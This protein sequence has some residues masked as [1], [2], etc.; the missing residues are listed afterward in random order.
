M[1]IFSSD[2]VKSLLRSIV[3]SRRLSRVPSTVLSID[4]DFEHAPNVNVFTANTVVSYRAFTPS[5]AFM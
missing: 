2:P 3:K 5:K 4:T 1:E